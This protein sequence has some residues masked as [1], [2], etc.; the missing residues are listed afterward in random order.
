MDRASAHT[1]TE[2][3]AKRANVKPNFHPIPYLTRFHHS[4]QCERDGLI[5]E[6]HMLGDKMPLLRVPICGAQKKKKKKK[7]LG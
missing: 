3:K 4:R 2:S 6:R 7:E 1:E 5:Q